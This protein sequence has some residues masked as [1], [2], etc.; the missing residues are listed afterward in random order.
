MFK[1]FTKHNTNQNFKVEK[2]GQICHN[3]Y[4]KTQYYKDVML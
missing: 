4:R 3:I 1:I 2:N